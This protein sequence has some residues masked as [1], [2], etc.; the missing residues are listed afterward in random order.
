MTLGPAKILS[1][2]CFTVPDSFFKYYSF[3]V[4]LFR[5]NKQ[6]RFISGQA[7]NKKETVLKGKYTFTGFHLKARNY[8]G[9]I[10]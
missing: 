1:R 6:A 5:K 7:I 4:L 8:T 9:R 2:L 3:F 10:E